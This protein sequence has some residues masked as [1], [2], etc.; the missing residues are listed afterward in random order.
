[1]ADGEGHRDESAERMAYDDRPRDPKGR[2]RLMDKVR[3]G[4][5]RP[6]FQAQALAVTETRPVKRNNPIAPFSLGADAAQLS[7]LECHRVAVEQN[8]GHALS[9]AVSIMETDAV[10]G[11]EPAGGRVLRLCL[12]C[13]CEGENCSGQKDD[14]SYDKRN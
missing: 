9:S 7:V 1:M 3:L 13:Q 12:A 2:Q 8:D 5:R 4:A 14:C 10:D 6:E 11:Q